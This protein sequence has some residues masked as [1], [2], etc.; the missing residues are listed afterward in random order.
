MNQRDD[1]RGNATTGTVREK[2]GRSGN[3]GRS[4][5]RKGGASGELPAR[6]RFQ[7][8]VLLRLGELFGRIES[9][10]DCGRKFKCYEPVHRRDND[11]VFRAAIL[12]ILDDGTRVGVAVVVMSARCGFMVATS[13][14]SQGR[15]GFQKKTMRRHR[16]PDDCQQEREHCFQGTHERMLCAGLMPERSGL[17]NLLYRNSVNVSRNKIFCNTQVSTPIFVLAT[18]LQGLLALKQN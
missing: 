9:Q 18:P 13:Q 16:Q 10:F 3:D 2:C 11:T 4:A 8:V 17:F 15:S 1:A 12:G 5:R 7:P 14:R 6:N